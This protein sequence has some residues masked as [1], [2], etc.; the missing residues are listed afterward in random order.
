[1]QSD[2]LD[3]SGKPAG[4]PAQFRS[5]NVNS[6]HESFPVC[7]H[8]WGPERE[9]WSPVGAPGREIRRPAGIPGRQFRRPAFR[10]PDVFGG[11]GGPRSVEPT[12]DS[13]DSIPSP[14][15]LGT[16]HPGV[17]GEPGVSARKSSVSTDQHSTI[18]R[19]L[20]LR[21]VVVASI[22]GVAGCSSVLGTPK[23]DRL[24][25]RY[26]AG[27]SKYK[28]GAEQHNEAVI[29]Y[30]SDEYEEV[31]RLI[32]AALEPLEEARTAFVTARDLAEEIDNA[33]AIAIVSKAVEQTELLIE[34]SKLLRETARGFANENF[35]SAQESYESYRETALQLSNRELTAPRVLQEYLD[36]GILDL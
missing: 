25:D 32:E 11:V 26:Q 14:S 18:S 22:P 2:S 33:D 12:A 16:D 4:F 30:R 24:L 19:R 1:M 9:L 28:T 34:A 10:Y 17:N 35:D 27:F 36:Q 3:S 23:A 31:Q 8:M 29:A 5:N 6:Y 7:N 15:S 21:S 20:L 13:R